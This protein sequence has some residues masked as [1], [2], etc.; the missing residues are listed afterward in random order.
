VWHGK[1][2]ES[3]RIAEDLVPLGGYM[4]FLAPSISLLSQTLKEWTAEA[5]APS[6]P[7]LC[8]RI[9]RVRHPTQG[10][11]GRA[12]THLGRDHSTRPGCPH[13]RD[14]RAQEKSSTGRTE[15]LSAVH[16][17]V[18]LRKRILRLTGSRAMITVMCVIFAQRWGRTRSE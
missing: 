18:I 5:E 8:A 4:L 3:L 11:R 13:R 12:P 15:K 10:L 17:V 14:R 9:P 7:L 1:D 16:Y 6:R 2:V